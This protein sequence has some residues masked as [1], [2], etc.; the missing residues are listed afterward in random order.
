MTEREIVVAYC[1]RLRECT[2]AIHWKFGEASRTSFDQ[3]LRLF[4]RDGSP[5][6]RAGTLEGLGI[7][8]VHGIGCVIEVTGG[9]IVDFDW[10]IDGREVFDGWRLRRY[11]RSRG[12]DFPEA[13]LVTAARALDGIVE[14]QP[15]WFAMEGDHSGR[16]QQR[17]SAWKQI[18]LRPVP[19][20]IWQT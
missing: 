12:E 2:R 5:G 14:T 4:P 17:D 1:E 10:D 8:Q 16:G 19:P 13:S 20:P 15:G 18:R 6:V 3:P 7:F 11:A 9:E